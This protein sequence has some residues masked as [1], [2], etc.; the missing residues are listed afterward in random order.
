[1]KALHCLPIQARSMKELNERIHD[2][3]DKADIIEVWLD[4]VEDLRLAELFFEE[5]DVKLP[6]LFVN[7]LPSER[8][9]FMGTP[10]EHAEIL[11]E[12]F[13]RGAHY[14]DVTHE[15]DPAHLKT[16]TSAKQKHSKLIISYHNFEQTPDIASLQK[17]VKSA[18]K[19][20]ADLVKI[21]TFVSDRDEN[22]VLFDLTKWAEDQEIPIITVGM[23]EEGRLSRIVCP[24]L[25]SEIYYAPLKNGEETAPGQFTKKELATIWHAMELM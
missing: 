9:D 11:R 24:L 19:K 20:G 25:G 18:H 7:K 16:I 10:D 12:A 22:T 6:F 1:M 15:I 13:E 17:I 3:E 5:A 4:S 14:V 8:G 21:A 2:A 23:G